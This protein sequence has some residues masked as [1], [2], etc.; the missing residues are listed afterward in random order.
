MTC[1][2]CDRSLAVAFR[3]QFC[4]HFRCP[5]GMAYTSKLSVNFRVHLSLWHWLDKNG[6]EISVGLWPLYLRRQPA[7]P[8]RVQGQAHWHPRAL[9]AHRLNPAFLALA[10]LPLRLGLRG[11]PLGPTPQC[12]Q[13]RVSVEQCG[14]G[15]AGFT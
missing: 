8:R 5:Y 6:A 11:I 12:D 14:G 9:A 13:S 1:E 2:T 4:R 7:Q 3:A 10:C 15:P